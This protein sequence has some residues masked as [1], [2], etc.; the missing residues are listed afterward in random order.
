MTT[1]ET[2]QRDDIKASEELTTLV[3]SFA[4]ALR[5]SP[6]QTMVENAQGFRLVRIGGVV[7]A[8]LLIFVMTESSA[9]ITSLIAYFFLSFF[10]VTALAM[11]VGGMR[12]TTVVGTGTA[13]QI[14]TT[15]SLK[16]S[17]CEE[18]NETYRAQ[19]LEEY[20]Y[21]F[22]FLKDC[23]IKK[24]L[25]AAV[26]EDLDHQRQIFVL[27]T[28]DFVSIL[29]ANIPYIGLFLFAAP[30]LVV[31]LVISQIIPLGEGVGAIVIAVVI[32][33][34]IKGVGY[35]SVPTQNIKMRVGGA[36]QPP[37]FAKGAVL[38]MGFAWIETVLW[39]STGSDPFLILFYRAPTILIHGISSGL[40][41][42]AIPLVAVFLTNKEWKT[43]LY[44]LCYILAAVGIHVGYNI[45]VGGVL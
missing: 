42:C 23:K 5:K 35:R 45:L 21:F 8:C 32:E 18:I 24:D 34:M 4:P 33:E 44:G 36:P 16:D 14:L 1:F 9:P 31:T 22:P 20:D 7:A 40:F 12:T 10:G 11:V 27:R 3:D 19:S 39:F 30:L 38:G 2:R 43:A 37:E 15:L 26:K 41:F 17:E 6:A 28:N 25:Y 29:E 13:K